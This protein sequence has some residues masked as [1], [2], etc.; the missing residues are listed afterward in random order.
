MLLEGTSVSLVSESLLSCVRLT[1]RAGNWHACA[2]QPWALSAIT[3]GYRLQFPMKPPIFNGILPSV[4][5]GDSACIVEQ[6]ISFIKQ[7]G[8]VPH[9]GR[10]GP[11]QPSEK[12]PVPYGYAHCAVSLY[13]L[14]GMV[15]FSRP[16]G[17]LSCLYTG[18]F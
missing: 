3:K 15:H 12:V 7:K 18:C 9:S 8:G 6:E 11:Q 1:A 13:S 2:V 10:T 16:T 14:R 17:S 4:A 5:S